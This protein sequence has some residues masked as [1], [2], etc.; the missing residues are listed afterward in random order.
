MPS[1]SPDV[2]PVVGVFLMLI[3][4]LKTLKFS[5]IVQNYPKTAI[6]LHVVDISFYI[7]S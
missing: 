6:N 7:L 4:L 2:K 3:T 5:E 1:Y